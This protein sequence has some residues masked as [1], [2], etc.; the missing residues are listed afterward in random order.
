MLY[1]YQI[2]IVMIL[3][4]TVLSAQNWQ[5]N[6]EKAKEIA[7]KE[8][9]PIILVFSGSDWCGPCIKLDNQ[10]WKSEEF[11]TYSNNNYVLV[12]AD[13]PRKKSNALS[14]E[15]I[16]QNENL[17]EKYNKQGY[18]PMVVIFNADGKVLGETSYKNLSPTAYIQHLQSFIK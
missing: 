4:T 7:H 11:K 10:I 16:S 17:A 18:F 13:F 14:K 9:K 3:L 1:K 6:F 8:S 2:S 15:Q 12:K 5:F